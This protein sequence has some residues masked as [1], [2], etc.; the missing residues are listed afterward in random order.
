VKAQKFIPLI[1]ASAGLLAYANSLNAPFI[2]DDR[3]HIVENAHIRQLWPPWDI[4]AHSSR[5]LL[6][7]SLALNY[8][9]GGLNPWGY[10][11]LSVMIHILAALALYGVVRGT[12][13]TPG[14]RSKWG[15]SAPWLAAVIALI[16]LLH[17][18]QTGAVTYTVQRGEALMGLFYLLTV[19]C[20]M[21][22]AGSARSAAWYAGAVGGCL[23]GMASKEV[24][25]TAP[26]MVLLYDR[27]FL[28]KS[29]RE[30]FQ[31]RWGLYAGLAATWLLLP[32]LMGRGQLEGGAVADWA[33]SA[34]F[35]YKGITPYQYG[36]TQAGVILHYLRLAV[37]PDRLCLDYGW[38][39]GWPL[40]TTVGEALPQLIVVAG[41][42]AATVWAWVRWP[43]LGFL[44]AWFF[45]ILSPTSSV[46][47]IA[48]VVFDHRMYL[49]LAAVIVLAVL[50]VDWLGKHFFGRQPGRLR[51][52]EW[53]VG[54]AVVLALA[55]LTAR[56]NDDYRSEQAIWGDT[57]LKCPGNPRAHYN[58][59][60]TLEHAGDLPDA[61]AQYQ[62]AMQIWP[63]YAEPHN[64]LG[65]LLLQAGRAQEAIKYLQEALRLRPALAEA[66]Y[67][68]GNAMAQEGRVK[69]AT[70]HWRQALRIKP[71]YAEAY[72]NLGIAA[73]QSGRL[74]EAEGLYNQ[75]LQIK[76]DLAEAHN[77][78]AYDLARTSRVPEAMAHYRRALEINPGYAQAANNLALLLATLPPGQG[79]DVTEGLALA[80]RACALTGNRVAANLD[81]LAI[82]LAASGRFS[83]A[84]P[85]AQQAIEQANAAGQTAF[86]GAI[87]A[88]LELY[89]AGRPY[90][91]GA[92]SPAP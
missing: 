44:G 66:Q 48:D 9:L 80:Q 42:L 70:E 18:L 75:A 69:E 92:S 45:I 2:F 73:S 19:Y 52:F 56:R 14:L 50:G 26:V 11:L 51:A 33:P 17:P 63:D 67:N 40:A 68:L 72:N 31:R 36:L 10:H 28:A 81:T 8:A 62:Q 61:A 64:N 85:A 35:S 90:R 24:M 79:G 86:A 59:G 27:V 16:W 25:V 22:G 39:I 12:L 87:E 83:E 7:L 84:I 1:L 58:Y 41:L 38:A 3:W 78:L 13:L 77:N 29:W 30:V 43:A 32:V 15:A 20:V 71:D 54:G 4:L 82:A 76:P 60:V 46:V 34:G 74:D 89:R 49:S 91:P 23:L 5:P 47:P 53:G 21:R 6:H 65:N 55:G 37:W 57:A 88:R